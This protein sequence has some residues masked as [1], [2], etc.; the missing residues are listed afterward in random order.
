MQRI[1]DH[2]QA[3]LLDAVE[4]HEPRE[5]RIVGRTRVEL[6][7]EA[8]FLCLN[9]QHPP[10]STLRLAALDTRLER[11][12][13]LRRCAAGVIWLVFEAVVRRRVM[14]RRNHDRPARVLL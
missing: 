5:L 9:Q 7:D 4:L 12:D 6:D 1:E 2:M 10:G 3:G 14:R 13:Y 11:L 8:L